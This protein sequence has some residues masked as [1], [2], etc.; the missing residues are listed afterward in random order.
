MINRSYGGVSGGSSKNVNP[1][2]INVRPLGHSDSSFSHRSY[3]K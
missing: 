3:W 1:S 2:V